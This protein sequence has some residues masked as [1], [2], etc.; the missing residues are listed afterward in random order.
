MPLDSPERRASAVSLTQSA[1]PSPTP[2]AG[3]DQE[4]RQESGWGYAA[5]LVGAPV[6]PPVIPPV[7][8]VAAGAVWAYPTIDRRIFV[9]WQREVRDFWILYFQEILQLTEAQ[10][11]LRATEIMKAA[12]TINTKKPTQ[13]FW[14]GYFVRAEEMKNMAYAIELDDEEIMSLL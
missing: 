1:P 4:W 2:N 6:V 3:M 12:E 10:A 7:E 9:S 8:E 13:S 11:R 5:I 14:K